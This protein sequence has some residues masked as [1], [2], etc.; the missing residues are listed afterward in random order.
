MEDV[1]SL[2]KQ[3][4]CSEEEAG[5]LVR[6]QA[7]QRVLEETGADKIAVAHN[8]NDNSETILFNLF[9]GTGIKGLTG[10]PVKRDNIV[11]P[12]LCCTRD[13]ILAFLDKINQQ[14]CTDSTNLATE[15][16]RNKIRLNILPEVR[17]TINEKADK[18]V[19]NAALQLEEISDYINK[20]TNEAYDIYV[21]GNILINE[22]AG[23]H[24]AILK[25]VI[26]R[27]IEKEAGKLKDVTSTH[28]EDV[29]KLMNMQV[30]KS[31][32]LPYGLLAVKVY[33]GIQIK[34]KDACSQKTVNID[35]LD[36]G[37]FIN[38]HGLEFSLLTNEFA[39][40]N[41]E[42][43]LYTKWLDYDKIQSL[44]LRNRMPG[45]YI[46]VDESGSKKKLKDYFI[47]EKIPKD[48]RD[49]ILLLADGSHVVWIIGHR[50]S[51]YYKVSD[52][53]KNILKIT[54]DKE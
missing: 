35:V 50:I 14:Y 22:A 15:Y 33:Q 10:I 26:R 5:R 43:I 4:A 21:E 54:Y 17:K 7:F 18:N 34:K 9:R 28:V 23:L 40:Q 3:W 20:N 38:T 42:D 37:E 16:T 46:V 36:D 29:L 11:R 13:E 45:D 49:K 25:N 31:V 41:I 52:T 24:P 8:L 12:L 27:I 39:Y 51:S 19:V 1:P 6:Y 30:S 2:A 53:T 47:N 32:D 48:D 44:T